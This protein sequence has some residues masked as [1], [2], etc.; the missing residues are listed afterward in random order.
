VSKY[1]SGGHQ[2]CLLIAVALLFIGIILLSGS[3]NL[4]EEIVPANTLHADD[5]K[6]G[7]AIYMEDA[8]LMDKYAYTTE[9]DVEK[10]SECALAFD[11]ADGKMAIASLHVGKSDKLYKVMKA[12]LDDDSQQIGDCTLNLCAVTSSL[13]TKFK[14]FLDDYVKELFGGL[15]NYHVTYL[16]LQPHGESMEEYIA[17]AQRKNKTNFTMGCVLSA[18]GLVLL[19]LG[20]HLLIKHRA[21]MRELKAQAEARAAAMKAQEGDS[22][23]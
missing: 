15:N 11:L 17:N 22:P 2:A 9:N 4:P 5:L 10:S 21:A 23:E 1:S 7:I 16:K 20:V 12:Y 6:T 13:G 14:G 8:I 3:A 18:I 19:A